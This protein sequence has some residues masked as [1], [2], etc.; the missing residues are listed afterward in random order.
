MISTA[1]LFGHDLFGTPVNTARNFAV[2]EV[3]RQQGA[4]NLHIESI[5]GVIRAFT[6]VSDIIRI[7]IGTGISALNISD[8]IARS[9]LA[10][11]DAAINVLC[12]EPDPDE[13]HNKSQFSSFPFN[14]EDGFQSGH[15]P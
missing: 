8:A 13:L 5:Q 7:C 1:L 6:A 3:H 12:V 2:V 9:P 11:Q 4:G 10:N 14:R 15:N